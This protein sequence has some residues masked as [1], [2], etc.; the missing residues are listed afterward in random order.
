MHVCACVSVGGRP[1]ELYR[2]AAL[3]CSWR[4]PFPHPKPRAQPSQRT[5][6]CFLVVTPPSTPAMQLSR[7][8]MFCDEGKGGRGQTDGEAGL[9]RERGTA[10]R[11]PPPPAACKAPA[12]DTRAPQPHLGGVHHQR[13]RRRAA[14]GSSHAGGQVANGGRARRGG[15]ARMEMPA[16]ARATIT[17][18]GG[19]RKQGKLWSMLAGAGKGRG[20]GSMKAACRG[21]RGG[22]QGWGEALIHV[23]WG[24]EPGGKVGA[25]WW[26]GG[27]RG[28]GAL[29]KRTPA[30]QGPL[31][32]FKRPPLRSSQGRWRARPAARQT[33]GTS[34]ACGQR[35]AQSGGV[36]SRSP[37]ERSAGMLF[38][39]LSV[40]RHALC[41]RCAHRRPALRQKAATAS[42]RTCAASPTGQSLP[43]WRRQ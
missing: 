12:W 3:R 34:P 26:G 7:S 29:S 8:W 11:C 40:G 23:G 16:P 4:W 43:S 36:S 5:C 21:S 41:R 35:D 13:R 15:H 25:R 27:E 30:L 20:E 19:A 28:G 33:A 10:V 6:T 39:R 32:A 24:R 37:S 31:P 1:L 22:R 38:C 9:Q 42:P 18:G 14:A 2:A 17:W